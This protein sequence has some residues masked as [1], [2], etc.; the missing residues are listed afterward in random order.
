MGK[1]FEIVKIRKLLSNYENYSRR[2]WFDGMRMCKKGILEIQCVVTEQAGVKIKTNLRKLSLHLVT[3]V[4][5]YCNVTIKSS[6]RK[7]YDFLN[8]FGIF[9]KMD[10]GISFNISTVALKWIH[11]ISLKD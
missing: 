6:H 2:K 4:V 11:N 1:Y 3:T 8:I 9:L 5:A 7:Y 10:S